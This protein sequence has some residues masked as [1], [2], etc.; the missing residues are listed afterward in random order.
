[1]VRRLPIDLDLARAGYLILP[2]RRPRPI[3][4]IERL[5]G[6]TERFGA[7]VWWADLPP[8]RPGLANVEMKQIL[9][10]DW[11]CCLKPTTIKRIYRISTELSSVR[12]PRGLMKLVREAREL[13]GPDDAG[14]DSAAAVA[15]EVPCKGK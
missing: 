3:P 14:T 9:L 10:A 4:D 8:F 11:L 1:M 6:D 7:E 12:M 15:S 13:G 2:N 5:A